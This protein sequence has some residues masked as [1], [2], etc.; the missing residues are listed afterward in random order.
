MI[1]RAAG[2]SATN[3]VLPARGSKA[4]RLLISAGPTREPL[5]PVRFLS[6]YSTGVMGACLAQ[7]ALTRGHRVTLVSGPTGLVPPQGLRVIWVERARQMQRALQQEF[8]KADALIMAAA[9]CD[10][11]A[12]RPRPAK[13][14]RRGRLRLR[15]KATPD[16]IGTLPRRP[17]QL[18]VGF[19]LETSAALGH[20]RAKLKAKRL[21][22]IVG[23]TMNG[24]SPFGHRRGRAFL[25]DVGG[26]RKP[27]G[28][29]SKPRLARA[30]LDELEQLWYG[31]RTIRRGVRRFTRSQQQEHS[32]ASCG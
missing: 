19:A 7:E 32:T 4:L 13:L 5:D 8:P 3:G 15:F 2:G 16:I 29:V 10:F 17:G 6:N 21:D 30:I 9:V 26:Q 1:P 28:T 24:P 14:S 22:L 31:D 27:L 20:A 23:Q 12:E 18:V 11:E 25:L